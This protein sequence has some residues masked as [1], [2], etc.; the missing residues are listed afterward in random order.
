MEP[1]SSEKNAFNP[2]I[3]RLKRQPPQKMFGI[4]SPT[5]SIMSPCSQKI[6]ANHMHGMKSMKPLSLTDKFKKA[7]KEKAALEK[8][9]LN[10]S[11]F[12]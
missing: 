3:Q 6:Q 11:D 8:E 1:N 10:E 9:N 7:Q 5:D 12:K 4:S 2:T